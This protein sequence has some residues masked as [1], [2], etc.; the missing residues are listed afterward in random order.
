MLGKQMPEK[1]VEAPQRPRDEP[2]PK[3]KRIIE[4]DSIDPFLFDEIQKVE[5]NGSYGSKIES[6]VRHL[7]YIEEKQPGS[8]SIV[9]TAWAHSLH[10][11]VSVPFISETRS[12]DIIIGALRSPRTRSYRKW[13]NMSTNRPEAWPRECCK[14]FPYRS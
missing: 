3:T 10:S 14:G 13:Y 11:D 8:K 9:F 2:A 1:V 4:Y 7:L 5:T 12:T 6:I